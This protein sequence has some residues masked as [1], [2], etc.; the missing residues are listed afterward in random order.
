MQFV[1]NNSC[2]HT[3]QISSNKLLHKFDYEIC[4][5]IAN[6]VI[7]RRISAV[8]DHIKKLHKLC[9]K[10]HQQLVEVQE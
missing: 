9:Q 3:T 5:D 10:L 2:N 8:K 6:N 7:E 1:Y 4:I